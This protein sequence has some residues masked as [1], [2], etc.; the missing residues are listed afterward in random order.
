MVSMPLVHISFLDSMPQ[1]KR[2]GAPV[3]AHESV[4][5]NNR[6]T[7]LFMADALCLLDVQWWGV[8]AIRLVYIELFQINEGRRFGSV[9][10]DL[11]E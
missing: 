2:V 4:Q 9:G 5:S 11:E 8:F 1:T 7:V 6:Y 3:R 10:G